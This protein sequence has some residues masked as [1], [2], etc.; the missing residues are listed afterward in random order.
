MTECQIESDCVVSD[1]TTLIGVSL[2][3]SSKV[4]EKVRLTNCVVMENVVIGSGSNIE[5]SIICDN[6]IISYKNTV[7]NSILGRGQKTADGTE[8]TSQLILDKDRMM[9][10]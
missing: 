1:K 4:E 6:C 10:V 3:A 2:G 8:I 9:E 7:K 5:D